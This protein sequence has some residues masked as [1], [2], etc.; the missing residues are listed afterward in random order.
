M[1]G[2][3]NRIKQGTEEGKNRVKVDVK[4]TSAWKKFLRTRKIM[5]LEGVR[6]NGKQFIQRQ[7]A[8]RSFI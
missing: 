7:T 8:L 3:S 4:L 2:K 6:A 5:S 1:L